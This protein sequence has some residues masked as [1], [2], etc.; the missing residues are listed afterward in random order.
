MDICWSTV[1]A[2]AQSTI[3]VFACLTSCISWRKTAESTVLDPWVFEFSASLGSRFSCKATNEAGSDT[4]TVQLQ[5]APKSGLI[6]HPQVRDEK[7]KAVNELEEWLHRQIEPPVE[8]KE[9]VA[10]VFIEPLQ[11]PP[12]LREGENAYFSARVT[13]TND[14]DLKV[15]FESNMTTS[16]SN[17]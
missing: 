9:K 16:L 10:P 3:S 5:V 2:S 14:P 6:L 13:P 17:F 15:S 11:N 12:P 8:V 4:T 1:T 7:V